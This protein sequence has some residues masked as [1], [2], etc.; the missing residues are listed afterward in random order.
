M[1][2]EEKGLDAATQQHFDALLASLHSQKD[3]DTIE[4]LGVS[5]ECF[6][7]AENYRKALKYIRRQIRSGKKISHSHISNT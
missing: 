7:D 2:E 3:L 6:V 1:L 4:Q 5:D